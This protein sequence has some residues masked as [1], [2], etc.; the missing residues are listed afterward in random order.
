[1]YNIHILIVDNLT[2]RE[3]VCL[4]A[5]IFISNLWLLIMTSIP[6][7]VNIPPDDYYNNH[8]GWYTGND[9]MRFLEP[10]FG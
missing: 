10:I 1:M 5:L 2:S 4:L 6:V 7:A 8:P 3:V 9:V